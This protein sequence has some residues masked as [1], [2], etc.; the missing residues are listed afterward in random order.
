METMQFYVAAYSDADG[1]HWSDVIWHDGWADVRALYD[2]AQIAA[3]LANV[4][5]T[6]TLTLHGPF[7]A[8][9]TLRTQEA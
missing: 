4:P 9:P 5:A 7:T 1:L 8:G 3:D 6:G 2:C